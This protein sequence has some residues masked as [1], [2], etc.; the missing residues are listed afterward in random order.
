ML[1]LIYSFDK[2]RGKYPYKVE[3]EFEMFI[4][5]MASVEIRTEHFKIIYGLLTVYTTYSWDGPSGPTFDKTKWLFRFYR[6]FIPASLPH[7]IIYQCLREN[8]L[9]WTYRLVGDLLIRSLL[10]KGMNGFKG[11]SKFRAGY[12]F[13]VLHMF[14]GKYAR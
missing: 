14:G 1:F 6:V 13:R 11:V 8:L 4:P 3:E 10:L 9:N 12:I 5:E 2:S 7:D